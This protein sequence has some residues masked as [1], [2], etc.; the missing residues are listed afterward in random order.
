MATDYIPRDKAIE[1]LVNLTVY[2]SLADI[3]SLVESK[4]H[5]QNEWIGGIKDALEEIDGIPAADVV[6]RKTGKWK[7]HYADHEAF[8]VRPFFRYCS[9]CNEATIYPYNFCPH[10]GADMREADNG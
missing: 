1:A 8:G 9:E 2:N 4:Y 3:K 5:Y 10:C 7:K 6:E